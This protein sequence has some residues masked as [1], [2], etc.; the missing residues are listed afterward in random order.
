MKITKNRTFFKENVKFDS[1]SIKRAFDFEPQ[2]LAI[3]HAKTISFF[4]KYFYIK[5]LSKLKINPYKYWG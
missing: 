1:R 5:S 4:L 2:D 3:F